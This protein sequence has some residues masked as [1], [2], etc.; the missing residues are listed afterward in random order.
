MLFQRNDFGGFACPFIYH[1][2]VD[3]SIYDALM[4]QH[5]ADSQNINA[6]GGKQRGKAVARDVESDRLC[7]EKRTGEDKT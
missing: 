2:R 5:S 1:F 4:G 3:L 6:I 7:K